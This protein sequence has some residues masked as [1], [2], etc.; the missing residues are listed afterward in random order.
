MPIRVMNQVR[1]TKD[2]L[3][4]TMSSNPGEIGGAAGHDDLPNGPPGRE[5]EGGDQLQLHRG[6]DRSTPY[7]HGR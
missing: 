6:E 1:A 2:D 7:R 4:D 5:A 3:A